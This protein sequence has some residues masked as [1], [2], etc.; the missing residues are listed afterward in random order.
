MAVFRAVGDVDSSSPLKF[1]LGLAA[2]F[3]GKVVSMALADGELSIGARI[4]G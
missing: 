3:D 4:A 1:T 2:D